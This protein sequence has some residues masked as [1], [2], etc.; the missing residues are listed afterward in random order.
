VVAVVVAGRYL[1]QTQQDV[2][3]LL[4]PSLYASETHDKQDEKQENNI[5]TLKP[6]VDR[7]LSWFTVITRK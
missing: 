5:L 1:R 3:V 7:R 4:N 2:S 6:S